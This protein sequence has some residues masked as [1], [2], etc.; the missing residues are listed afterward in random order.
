V[1]ESV[2]VD[3]DCTATKRVEVST[4]ISLIVNSLFG[5]DAEL[6]EKVNTLGYPSTISIPLILNTPQSRMVVYDFVVTKL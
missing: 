4:L 3:D 5:F 2:F 1:C 6:Y